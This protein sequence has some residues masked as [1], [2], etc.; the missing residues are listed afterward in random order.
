MGDPIA[1]AIAAAAEP[2][3][4]DMIQKQITIS[5]TGRPA[6]ILV[7]A[8]ITAAELAELCGWMLTALRVETAAPRPAARILW[9]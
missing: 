9:V 3:P 8:D 7:P 1:A 6:A 5:S 4:V 2:Q